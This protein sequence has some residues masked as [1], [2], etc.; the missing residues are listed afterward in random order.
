MIDG[1]IFGYSLIVKTPR[2]VMKSRCF[3]Q[4]TEQRWINRSAPRNYVHVAR[5]IRVCGS[6]IAVPPRQLLR[7]LGLACILCCRLSIGRA[8]EFTVNILVVCVC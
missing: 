3:C 2:S 7:H 6:L 5:K 8:D 1:H 4:L